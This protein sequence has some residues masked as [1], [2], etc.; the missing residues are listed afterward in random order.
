MQRP[1]GV[2][3]AEVQ[4]D[5]IDAGVFSGQTPVKIVIK[6]VVGMLNWT[7]QWYKTSGSN[8]REE[9]VRN[10]QHIFLQGILGNAWIEQQA[11]KAGAH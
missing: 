11:V 3:D 7:Y 9:I 1:Q 8:S 10:F 4:A 2:D 6:Q 5:G